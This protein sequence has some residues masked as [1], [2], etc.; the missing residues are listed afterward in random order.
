MRKERVLDA[1]LC[2]SLGATVIALVIDNIFLFNIMIFGLAIPIFILRYMITKGVSKFLK[3]L[4]LDIKFGLK[5]EKFE[6]A[7]FIATVS[8]AVCMLSLYLASYRTPLHLSS[9]ILLLLL[10]LP[11][12]T[13]FL[14]ISDTQNSYIQGVKQPGF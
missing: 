11:P 5:Y 7:L 6:F 14:L 2:I 4:L 3:E 8:C 13:Y 12:L 9:F 1:L 10:S